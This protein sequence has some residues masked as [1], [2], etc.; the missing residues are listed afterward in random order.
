MVSGSS[1]CRGVTPLLVTILADPSQPDVARQRAFGRFLAELE[2]W[3]DME[4]RP[5]H[6]QDDGA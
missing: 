3:N 6:T 2:R 5:A 1:R 4:V